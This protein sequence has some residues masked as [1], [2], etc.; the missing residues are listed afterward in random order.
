M[1]EDADENGE[2]LE[3]PRALMIDFPQMVSVDHPD[4]EKMFNRDVNGIL[5]FFEDKFDCEVDEEDRP[6]FRQIL[7]EQRKYEEEMEKKMK[8]E[9][10]NSSKTDD[11]LNWKMDLMDAARKLGN[12]MQGGWAALP[13]AER[14]DN[15]NDESESASEEENEENKEVDSESEATVQEAEEPIKSEDLDADQDQISDLPSTNISL[16]YQNRINEIRTGLSAITGST[17]VPPEQIKFKVKK[18]MELSKYRS[19][20]QKL[21]KGDKVSVRKR[22]AMNNDIKAT[23]HGGTKD[24]I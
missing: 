23:L 17:S 13:S 8:E 10:E 21:R 2:P 20:V 19:N 12:N 1:I 9:A 11:I 5:R 18:A 16:E 7:E 22:Q 14:E 24:F 6:D 15:Q 4:A 3:V